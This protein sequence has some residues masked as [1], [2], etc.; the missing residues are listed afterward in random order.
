MES[1]LIEVPG[2]VGAIGV[3]IEIFGVFVIVLGI[4]SASLSYLSDWM[5]HLER[6]EIYDQLRVRIAK[7]L[8]LGLEIL[9][10][11]DIIR[12]VALD[13]NR[14]NLFS[15][16]L[17]VVIRTILSWALVVEIEERWPWQKRV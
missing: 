14:E 6:T 7:T 8:L 4:L 3:A 10:A 12:T 16:G 15:L 17:L 13:P 5:K 11:A 1:L 9:V 2:Y